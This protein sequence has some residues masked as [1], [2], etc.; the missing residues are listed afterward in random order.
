MP[1]G[2]PRPL[3]YSSFTLYEECPQKYKFRYI[4]RIPEK[5]KHYFSFGQSVHTALEFFYGVKAPPA[6]T[7]DAVLAHYKEHW[8]SRGYKDE[9]T[10]AQYFQEGKDLITLFYRK[11]VPEFHIPLFVEYNFKT[12]ME[13]IPVTGKVDRIDRLEDGRLS[14]VDYKTGKALD[15]A[16]VAEDTQLAMYQAACE[17]LL[18][19]E[20]ARLSFYHLPSLTEHTL[21]RR[22]RE[23]IDG[24]KKRVVA[25]ADGIT[26]GVFAPAP[27]ETKCRFCDY[28]S[29]CPVFR[30]ESLK[31]FARRV[32]ELAAPPADARAAG[33]A[34][35]SVAAAS[36]DS[37]AELAATID[38]LGS[39]LDEVERLKAHVLAIF[40]KK[41]Y[42]RAFGSRYQA[43]KENRIRWSFPDKKRVLELLR[44]A[45]IYEKTLAPS[46]PKIEAFLGDPAFPPD[47]RARLSELSEK[48]ETIELKLDEL[49]S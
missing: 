24:V 3:S 26:K 18:G 47:I 42:A 11:H 12:T 21:P 13:G 43:V 5:P 30:T 41:G 25:A 46:Q 8:V 15:A 32:P 35:A 34:S 40:Q 17:S 2:L 38:K 39:L 48:I 33:Q 16:R 29:L 6:P 23:R 27:Q 9:E 44:S 45:G 1:A 19:A 20:V 14:I 31:S 7:L 36:Q 37:D 49:S 4:D 28:R 22:P 10:E